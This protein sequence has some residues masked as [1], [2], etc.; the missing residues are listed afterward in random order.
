MKLLF[1]LLAFILLVSC[2]KKE[3]SYRLPYDE[4]DFIK[5]NFKL[6]LRTY[7][8]H[9]NKREALWRQLSNF[10]IILKKNSPIYAMQD[11]IVDTTII[12]RTGYGKHVKIRHNDSTVI[13]YNHLDT[14][15]I[16]TDQKIK[17]GEQ[18][19]IVG[20]TGTCTSINLGISIKVNEKTTNP[21]IILKDLL[22][23]ESKL[24]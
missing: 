10:S 3:D 1:C 12:K 13:S 24:E 7:P 23:K 14:F 15:Y 11:G 21:R 19:G 17:K 16:H 4:E 9:Y 6:Q 2:N 20:N 18:I 8:I 22:S 5:D